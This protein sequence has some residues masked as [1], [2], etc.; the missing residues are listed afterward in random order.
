MECWVTL[1]IDQNIDQNNNDTEK[2]N[3]MLTNV[4]Y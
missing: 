3:G 4:E 2:Q 1:N